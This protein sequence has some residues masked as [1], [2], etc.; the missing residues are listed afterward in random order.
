M[1]IFFLGIF[2]VL[3]SSVLSYGQRVVKPIEYNLE[4][5]QHFQKNA[6]LRLAATGDTLKL[7]FFDDFSQSTISPDLQKWMPGGGTYINNQYPVN[8]PT[9]NVATFDGLQ[10]N[11]YP[12]STTSANKGLADNL[13]SRPI[14]LSGLNPGDSVYL[15]YFWQGRGIGEESDAV[16]SIRLQLKSS[17]TPSVW[18]TV[19]KKTGDS[20]AF[21]HNI[22]RIGDAAKYFYNGFQFRF[23]SYGRRSGSY[24]IWNVDYIYLDTGRLVKENWT[25]DLSFTTTPSS[26]LKNYSAMPINQYLANPSAETA[27]SIYVRATNL[28]N[29]ARL[30]STDSSRSELRDIKNNVY[31]D[32]TSDKDF[33]PFPQLI[34]T[35]ESSYYRKEVIFSYKAKS[36][37]DKF[38]TDIVPRILRYSFVM[39]PLDPAKDEYFLFTSGADSIPSRVNFL[40]NDSI[41]GTTYLTDYYSY[42]DGSAEFGFGLNQNL[43]KIAVQ[44]TLNSLPDTIT[45][46]DI[47]F[48]RIHADQT[49]E[50][51]VLTVWSSV[52]P[53]SSA[54]TFLRRQAE[55]LKHSTALNTFQRYQLTTPVIVNTPTFYVG[56]QQNTSE[57][58]YT[59][60]DRNTDRRNKIFYTVNGIWRQEQV[61]AGS[62]M[63]RPVF[64][65]AAPSLGTFDPQNPNELECQVFPNPT[66]GE[67]S[68][69]GKISSMNLYDLSGKL[70]LSRTYNGKVEEIHQENFS[71]LPNG[72]YIMHLENEGAKVVKKIVL[73]Q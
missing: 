34:T 10:E 31:I 7:P 73:N 19:W 60:F 37:L 53:G 5:A 55:P 2:F 70:L 71:H 44:Y 24:D 54:E 27:D 3:F 66:T 22:I 56:Y 67:I 72:F 32:T 29:F 59:G 48:P 49:G 40:Q 57:P 23:E 52:T 39:D 63:I 14:D 50:S 25:P 42:D 36:K 58:I 68:I 47:Y 45:H 6:H 61:E 65:D 1:K 18:R 21:N 62:L 51:L 69:A 11:G 20:T 15:K 28:R 30:I 8:P 41:S 43:G 35:P 64:K 9:F 12:Y 16:D 4:Q 46:I 26:F 17:G 13:T 38:P 33:F